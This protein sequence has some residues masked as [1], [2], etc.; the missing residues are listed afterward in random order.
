MQDSLNLVSIHDQIVY[1]FPIKNLE[2][3][4]PLEIFNLSSYLVR[5]HEVQLYLSSARALA[6]KGH[7]KARLHIAADFAVGWHNVWQVLREKSQ[8]KANKRLLDG[9][10]SWPKTHLLGRRW[11]ARRAKTLMGSVLTDSWNWRLI[12]IPNSFAMQIE[13]GFDSRPS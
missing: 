7:L 3:K 1:Q 12:W 11:G 9:P 13:D 4:A 8:R 5:I 6:I 10:F 2:S